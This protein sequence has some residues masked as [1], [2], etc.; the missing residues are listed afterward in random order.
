MS[1]FTNT[2]D[3]VGDEVLT[4]SIIDRS[5]TEIADNIST[6]IGARTFYGC[7]ALL[8]ADFRA[9]TSLDSFAF[10]ECSALTKLDFPALKDVSRYGLNGISNLTALIL[11]SETVC[12]LYNRSSAMS[13]DSGR[14]YLY[15]PRVLVDSYKADNVW[16]K[17]ASKIRAIE[18]YPEI[19]DPYNWDVVAKTIQNNTYKDV[20]KVGD[21]VPLDLGSIGTV[22][23]QIAAFD[24]DLLADGSGTA[25]ISWVAKELL[26]ARRRM[27]PNGTDNQIG[28]GT[29]GG[30]ENSELRAYLMDTIQPQISTAAAESIVAVAKTQEAYDAAGAK[31]SQTTADEVWIPNEAEVRA[32]YARLF[33]TTAARVKCARG[34]TAPRQW[35]L[36]NCTS[37]SYFRYV[38]DDG[39]FSQSGPSTSYWICFGFCTGRT[40]ISPW[41][42]VADS[43]ADGTYKTKYKIG[44]TVPL[45]L[46][47]E[48]VINMQIAAFDADTLAD[49]SGTAAISWIGKELLVPTQRMNPSI[50]GTH[51]DGYVEGTGSIGGWEKC[52]MRAYLKNTIKPL[53]P[54]KVRSCI[55]EVSKTQRALD[56]AGSGYTQTT[57]DDV[58]IPAKDEVKNNSQFYQSLFY[59]NASRVKTVAGTG[60]RKAWWLRGS[61]EYAKQTECFETVQHDG[62]IL[63][64]VSANGA[65]N[66]KSIALGFCTGKTPT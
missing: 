5:I 47:S 8:K 15:V 52:E 57:T 17:Y 63:T 42:E 56:T 43:I 60:E 58:W 2:V 49:G 24:T 53:I 46:G 26:P 3:V 59:D 62:S 39:D 50:Q 41:D 13:L 35:W 16:S 11:R 40:P 22:N 19:C 51:D 12:S 20:Y 4:N 36:R 6:S 25:A 30:W 45:S 44:D 9:A 66:Q 28:T 18:D 64:T 65:T 23:M 55:V 27:N 37:I 32:A 14:C 21:I 38:D 7:S 1:Y 61:T 31:F 54:T 10:D 29:Y 48:G 33:H 34:N